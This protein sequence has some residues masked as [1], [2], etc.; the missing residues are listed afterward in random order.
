[1]S[2]DERRA[3]IL[4]RAKEVFAQKSYREASTGELA[5]ASEITEPILYKHFGSKK[6]L[7]IAVLNMIG[8][9]FLERLRGLVEKRARN[10]LSDGLASFLLDYRAAALAD[11]ESLHLLLNAILE[12]NDPEIAQITQ[13]HNR[14]MYALISGLLER[15][16]GQRLI[17]SHIDLSAAAWGYLSFVFALQFRAKAG[18]FSQFS[19]QAIREI[20]RLWF[21]ALQ[22]GGSAAAPTTATPPS[23]DAQDS[24][25]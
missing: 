22:T 21:Q 3:L 14:E 23:Q 15:A 6:K 10:D 17:S 24:T 8:E 9:Q 18:I 13:A 19:E 12:S 7:Y 5:R 16:Q 25:G 20:N 2:G 4:E 11:H 1:M